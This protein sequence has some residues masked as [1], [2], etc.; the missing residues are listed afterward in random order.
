L[1]IR[2]NIA[3]KKVEKSFIRLPKNKLNNE[4]VS[5]LLKIFVENLKILNQTT[6]FLNEDLKDSEKKGS[7]AETFSRSKDKYSE[8]WEVPSVRQGKRI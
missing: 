8:F 6:R 1:E 3:L 2:S 7:I 4:S 5:D